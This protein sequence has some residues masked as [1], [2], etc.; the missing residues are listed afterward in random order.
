MVAPITLYGIRTFGSLL[1]I[2]LNVV[3]F[4]YLQKL[5]TTQ[6]I[7]AE[8]KT[9]KFMKFALFLMICYLFVNMFIP[10]PDITNETSAGQVVYAGAK[11][12]FSAIALVYY[13][14]MIRYI[15]RLVKEKCKCSE[16]MRRDITYIYAVLQLVLFAIMIILALLSGTLFA[17]GSLKN[18]KKFR[19]GVLDNMAD[20][21]AAVKKTSREA[22]RQILTP[23]K[24]ALSRS[25]K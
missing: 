25:R 4:T 3:A 7:C 5:E 10:I 11:L 24:K 9:M 13:I 6:C 23:V 2:A 22:N 20:P 8:D 14:Y 12:A 17:V 15:N 21:I 16:E 1:A 18:F 19:D